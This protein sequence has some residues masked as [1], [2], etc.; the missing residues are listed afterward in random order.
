MNISNQTYKE[1]AIPYFKETFDCIDQIMAEYGIPYYLIGVS[2]IAL[3][4]LKKGIKPS[5]GTKDIDFAIMISSMKEYENISRALIEKG[6]N[7]VKA[8]WTFYSDR[9]NVAIDVLPFGEIEEQHTI[10]FSKRHADLHVLG[11]SEVLEEAVQIPIDE[12][13]VNI[14]PLPGMV[15]LKLIAWSDR[16]EERE[17]DLADIL[18]VIQHYFDLEFDEIV[19]FHN[20]TF[21]EH[22]ELDPMLIAAEVLGRKSKVFLS[23]S[24]KLASRVHKVLNDNL[25]EGSKSKIAR[26]WARK[27]DRSIEYCLKILDAFRRGIQ[28]N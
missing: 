13:F 19:E 5:R 27:L 23:K 24:E 25:S 28:A 15:I 3:E 9:Y 4:L 26:E 6:Y 16:P 8:P 22:E 18:R 2:A 14:P 20:D 10:N 17:N 12:K 11:F 21:P 1:L 7:K